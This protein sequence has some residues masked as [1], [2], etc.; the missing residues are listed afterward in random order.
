MTWCKSCS[1]SLTVNCLWP[2]VTR[3]LCSSL[4]CLTEALNQ[5]DS[6][7]LDALMADL[8]SI[9]QEL[10]TIGKPSGS[11]ARLGLTGEA[12]V[13]Q[14]PPAG[15]SHSVKHTGSGGSSGGSGGSSSS[16]ST[17]VSPASTIRPALAS[18]FSLDD[19]TAQLERASQ[20]MDDAARL[21]TASLASTASAPY[22]SSTMRRPAHQH[23]RRTGSVGTAIEHE[24]RSIVHS[25]RSSINSA[26]A[27][28]VD[29]LEM[30]KSRQPEQDSLQEH[31]Q[32]TSEVT[33]S[34]IQT[35][36]SSA[37]I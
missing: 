25:S 14:K 15:R 5:G 17:R 18:N 16:S 23:H 26:S 33:V 29:S 28:S 1:W 7:D 4:F 11:S 21:S 32:P 30:D 36:T 9:E 3:C 6:V 10:S 20:S 27:S 35:L 31:S 22:S 24:V 34:L 37:N 2:P 13:R 12:K 8:C 19:I